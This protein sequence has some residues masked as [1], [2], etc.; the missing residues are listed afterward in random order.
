MFIEKICFLVVNFAILYLV[1]FIIYDLCNRLRIERLLFVF[2]DFSLH[3]KKVL[4]LPTVVRKRL[5]RMKDCCFSTNWQHVLEHSIQNNHVECLKKAFENGCELDT[6][7]CNILML[8]NHKE[9]LLYAHSQKCD[10][11]WCTCENVNGDVYKCVE[12]GLDLINGCIFSAIDSDED[13]FNTDVC[14]KLAALNNE[15][16]LL[17]AHSNGYDWDY[18]TCDSVN[19]DVNKCVKNGLHKLH[20]V[21]NLVC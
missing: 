21:S 16:C 13:G 9:C 17:F 19:R 10:W 3:L 20:V 11:D 6:N 18:C 14:D 1:Y 2:D 8:L 5:T 7:V 12:N 15:K 4:Y